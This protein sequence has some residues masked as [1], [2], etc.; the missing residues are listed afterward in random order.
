MVAVPMKEHAGG[1]SPLRPSSQA[2]SLQATRIRAGGTPGV[3]SAR[4]R[5][6]PLGW[7]STGEQLARRTTAP[8]A[9]EGRGLTAMGRHLT[10]GHSGA[11][12]ADRVHADG[13]LAVADPA[14]RARVLTLHPRRVLTVLGNPGVIDHPRGDADL[15]RH[16]FA[17][18][19]AP[20]AP[21]P[22]ASR[23]E[24]A[25]PTHTGPPSPPAETASAA[26]SSGRRCSILLGE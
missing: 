13:D 16:L 1:A 23:P 7:A 18:G 17:A 5:S 25:A 15:G 22:R 24:T 12:L 21:D 8:R 20:T 19:V 9:T 26:N 4:I 11:P 6:N 3:F 14:Q 2:E 10:R